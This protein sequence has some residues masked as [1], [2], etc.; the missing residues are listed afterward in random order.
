MQR[1]ILTFGYEG[2]SADAFIARL[3]AADIEMVIDVRA[4][5]ISRKAG[6]S[7]NALARNLTD[8]SVEYFHAAEMGCPKAV[9]DRYK[10]DGDWAAYTSAF[11][12]YIARQKNSVAR[13]ASIAKQSRSC[14]ICFEADF[15]FCHRTFVARAAAPMFNARIVH[16]TATASVEDRGI[17]SAA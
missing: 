3:K 10:S 7:K 4:N 9:R 12:N 17:R 1:E 6:L 11:L 13:V 16:L 2:L 15:H 5:P 14:L 8:V